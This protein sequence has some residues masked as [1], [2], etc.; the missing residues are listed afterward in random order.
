[1]NDSTLFGGPTEPRDEHDKNV[2]LARWLQ[3]ITHIAPREKTPTTLAGE[4]EHQLDLVFDSD[5]HLRFY[6]QLPDFIMTLL[7]NDSQASLHYAPLLYHLAGCQECHNSYL[8]LYD[9][10]REALF[11]RSARPLLGQGTRTLEATPHRILGHL[12]QTLISQAEA[13]LRQARRDRSERESF[14]GSSADASARSL[15]QLALHVS[16]RISQGSIRRY[17]LHD[18]VRVATLSE[19]SEPPRT[20]DSHVYAY[21]PTIAGVGAR[22]GKKIVRRADMLTRSAAGHDLPIIHLQARA[23]IGSI[24]QRGETLELHLQDLDQTL[25][26][27]RVIVSVPLGSLIEP[28]RWFGGNPRAIRSSA[29]VDHTGALAVPLGQTDL[30]LENVEDRNLLEAMFLLLEVRSAEES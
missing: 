3:Q 28:I 21:T 11:P 1:M 5:Y 26:G 16:A 4:S 25:R 30:R 10:M 17:A 14:V 2:R 12:C 22:R 29:P 23:L 13:V 24:T 9:S 8:D 15:L 6:Q 18:L 19:D 7:T 20:D 27:K